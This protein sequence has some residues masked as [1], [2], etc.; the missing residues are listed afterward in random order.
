MTKEEILHLGTLSRLALTSEEA[1]AFKTEIDAVLAYVSTV[2]AIAGGADTKT[3]GVRYNVMREDVIT[4]APG[5]YT[6]VLLNAAPVREGHYVAV[7]K[8]IDQSQ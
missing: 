8:I 4:N 7:K 6:E 3:V 1:E 2:T 5:Q